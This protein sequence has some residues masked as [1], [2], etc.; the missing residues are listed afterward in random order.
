MSRT[1]RGRASSPEVCLVPTPRAHPA[2]KGR[3]L[4]QGR[5]P[6]GTRYHCHQQPPQAH[7]AAPPA[8]D[9]DPPSP[10]GPSARRERAWPAPR[11][12]R[13]TG[14]TGPS[15]G[16]SSA[17]TACCPDSGALGR[18]ERLGLEKVGDRA[19]QRGTPL[20][21]VI[22]GPP[23]RIPP[24]RRF[25]SSNQSPGRPGAGRQMPGRA[26]GSDCAHSEDLVVIRTSPSADTQV[27][28]PTSV[29][30]SRRSS[31]PAVRPAATGCGPRT[32]DR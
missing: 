5:H 9:H 22:G 16:C 17:P 28:R 31:A 32:S 29:P 27:V 4:A 25:P 19:A 26:P 7:W 8:P 20:V 30:G 24:H 1:G 23:P 6:S 18:R 15:P 21:R 10:A 14:R 11:R 3:F 12:V 2:L 13:G